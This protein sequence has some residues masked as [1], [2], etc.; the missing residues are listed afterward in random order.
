MKSRD[1][2]WHNATVTRA[3]RERMNRHKGAV[4]WFTGLS[5][6]GKS[7][8]AHSVEDRLYRLGCR[9]YVFDGDNVRHGLCGDLGFTDNDRRENVRRIVET[10]KLFADAG[11]IALAAFITPFAQ[12]RDLA[13]RRL[14]IDYNEVYCRCTLE[15]CE[16][17]DIKG[18]YKR[19]RAGEIPQFTG[20]S[21]P[22]E[23]PNQADLVLDT[24]TRPLEECVNEVLGLL[25][26]KGVIGSLDGPNT[27]NVEVENQGRQER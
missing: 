14:G 26:I 13:R 25:V 1:V 18:M 3:R 23:E 20:V 21:S 12:D 9:T 24:G 22:Y 10:T 7:T 6:A 11:I 16:R 17:R 19:A 2:V 8:L 15:I 5:G 27:L 4:V